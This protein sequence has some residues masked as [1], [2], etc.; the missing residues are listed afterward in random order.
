[1]QGSGRTT[2]NW[3]IIL[4]TENLTKVPKTRDHSIPT[5]PRSHDHPWS[6]A[7]WT[8]GKLS[9]V[10]VRKIKA[11][12]EHGS[13]FN[14]QRELS[15]IAH[16]LGQWLTLQK[17]ARDERKQGV[18]SFLNPKQAFLHLKTKPYLR[19][20]AEKLVMAHKAFSFPP[21]ALSSPRR[22]SLPKCKRKISIAYD[23]EYKAKLESQ[24]LTS[25]LNCWFTVMMSS[26]TL[27]QTGN[28]DILSGF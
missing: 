20:W 11:L 26:N 16:P 17:L 18:L 9:S 3:R 27:R 14:F 25:L 21:L 13:S 19:W 7:L 28:K 12:F 5:L 23:S 24:V 2:G 15:I 6:E 4:L 8:E 10:K 22:L 1:M